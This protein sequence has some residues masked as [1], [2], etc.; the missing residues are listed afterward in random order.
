MNVT[1]LQLRVSNP[2][3]SIA[4]TLSTWSNPTSPKRERGAPERPSFANKYCSSSPLAWNWKRMDSCASRGSP[5]PWRMNPSKSNNG[6][7]L[8][9]VE[10][11]F[12][13]AVGIGIFLREIVNVIIVKAEWI[14]FVGIIVQIFRPDV[15]RIQLEPIVETLAHSDCCAAIERLCGTG[16]VGN[17]PQIREWGRARVGRPATE[18]H[19]GGRCQY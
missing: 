16:R 15:I 10:F 5:T 9:L 4:T 19:I 11:M 8:P 7:P 14:S 17:R 2:S 18:I 13:V 12:F 1:G 6:V 3:L